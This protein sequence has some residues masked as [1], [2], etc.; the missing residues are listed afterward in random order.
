MIRFLAILMLVGCRTPG[1]LSTN[2]G[3]GVPPTE[4]ASQQPSAREMGAAATAKLAENYNSIRGVWSDIGWW[5][6]ANALESVIDYSR[7]TGSGDYAKQ[8]STTYS[9]HFKGKFL[10]EFNDD[11]AWWALTWIKAYDLT[12]HVKYLD[13]AKTIFANL[14]THWDQ[15]CG[16]GVWWK[17]DHKYKN[18]ITN[19]LFLT[20]ASRLA[21]RAS[22]PA[23]RKE[24]REW[25]EREWSW[26]EKSTL[27]RTDYLVADGLNENCHGVGQTFTYNQGVI[28][29]GLADYGALTDDPKVYELAQKIASSAITKLVD[30]SGILRDDGESASSENQDQPQFK[31]IFVRYL[32]YFHNFKPSEAY[33]QFILQNLKSVWQSNR[34][35]DGWFGYLW[36]GPFDK[37]ESAR[38][39]AA[40]DLINAAIAVSEPNVALGAKASSNAAPCRDFE[41]ADKAVDG[42]LID[43][44]KWCAHGDPTATLTLDLKGE[45]TINTFI[46][47]HA[48]A[49][50]EANDFNT[51]VF[52]IEIS[53]D[54]VSWSQAVFV[55]DNTSSVT[56]HPVAALRARF[57]RLNVLRS[58]IRQSLFA[59]RIYEL[60][61]ISDGL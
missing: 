16:G 1:P 54:G 31:G 33:R 21:L 37:R 6:S 11:A 41:S 39:T 44:S 60:E 28:L 18:A 40:V 5:N 45:K 38:H 29:G 10:N 59:S 7:L 25:A 26:F 58:Q 12:H 22:K 4:S 3:V 2:K 55:T 14:T 20:L 47:K 32:A 43:G 42:S 27:I 13:M 36:A 57:V 50:G 48:G 30:Q 61:A 49:G 56:K 23:E 15:H 19:E 35:A 9:R 8:I 51:D 24:Y 34:S 53:T 52:T 46:V 17:I